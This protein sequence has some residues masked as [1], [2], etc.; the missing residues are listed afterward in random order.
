MSML[1]I[2]SPRCHQES[3]TS[4][5][6]PPQHDDATTPAS[7]A[8]RAMQ[9]IRPSWGRRASLAPQHRTDASGARVN[10]HRARSSSSAWRRAPHDRLRAAA[11]TDSPAARLPEDHGAANDD[12]QASAAGCRTASARRWPRSAEGAARCRHHSE[13]LHACAPAAAAALGTEGSGSSINLSIGAG[14][15]GNLCPMI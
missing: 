8:R 11:T 7:A 2:G 9:A 15:L 10:P 6:P 14:N 3:K 4:R 13:L 5:P 12:G 1:H